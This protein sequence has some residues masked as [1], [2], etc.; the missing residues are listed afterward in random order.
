MGTYIITILLA[1]FL[2]Y[3]HIIVVYF[4]RL[5]IHKQKIITSIGGGISLSYVFLHLMPELAASASEK[6]K[7]VIDNYDIILNA[8]IFEFT[9]FL[10]SFLGLTCLFIVDTFCENSNKKKSQLSLKL[11]LFYSFAI[12]FIYSFSLSEVV[13]EGLIYSILFT[14]T[15]SAHIF[16]S[17]R[18]TMRHHEKLFKKRYR[19]YGFTAIFLGLISSFFFSNHDNLFSDYALAFF[20]GG[21][22]LNAFLEELPKKSLI[23]IKWFLISVICTTIFIFISLIFKYYQMN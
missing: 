11:N 4:S 22:L 8:K 16:A 5:S 10:A 12:N 13:K 9:I 17:D 2:S 7:F 21:I 1:T 15:L 6:S 3:I 20:S 19:W 18:V 14:L 23:N